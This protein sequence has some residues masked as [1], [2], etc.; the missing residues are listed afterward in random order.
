MKSVFD[1]DFQ[2]QSIEAKIVVAFERLS[3]A[4]RTQLWDENKKHNLSPLQIQFLIY[5]YFHPEMKAGVKRLA[6][7]FNVTKPTA[8]EAVSSSIK[9][10]YISERPDST[11][12]RRKN[13]RLTE[14]GNKTARQASF[15]ANQIKQEIDPLEFGQ[16]E[17]VLQSLLDVVY[18]LQQAGIISINRMC[19]QC[20]YFMRSNDPD[21]P[22][23][24]RLLQQPLASSDL[25]IDCPE[26]E[27]IHEE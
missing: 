21:R 2:N 25:R 14:K 5:L 6:D 16:K 15:F 13:L 17:V 24:C 12:G 18:N 19:Y 22:H 8:S 3:E 20:R 7:E 9:K 4:F 10:G 23:Y 11:D 26:F 1:P 27:S